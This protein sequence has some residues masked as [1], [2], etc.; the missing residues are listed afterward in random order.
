MPKILHGGSPEVLF[1]QWRLEKSRHMTLIMLMLFKNQ[2][3]QVS[4][5]TEK[6]QIHGVSTY[7]TRVV[8]LTAHLIKLTNKINL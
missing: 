5:V 7:M 4:T 8:A 6:Q 3:G 1:Q 2:I